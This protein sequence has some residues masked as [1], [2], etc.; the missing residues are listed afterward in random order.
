MSTAA[1]RTVAVRALPVGGTGVAWGE[2]APVPAVDCLDCLD[3]Y[4]GDTVLPALRANLGKV[5]RSAWSLVTKAVDRHTKA[6]D[7]HDKP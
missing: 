2:G 1:A 3:H 4:S 5:E 6:V 7:R